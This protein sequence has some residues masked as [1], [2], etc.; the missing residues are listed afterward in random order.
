MQ[1]PMGEGVAAGDGVGERVVGGAVGS[2]MES[3][4]DGK[5][6]RRS[7]YTLKVQT[8]VCLT[9]H[10]RSYKSAFGM[11]KLRESGM[12]CPAKGEDEHGVRRKM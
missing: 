2:A 1:I 12:P 4:L 7:H 9:S 5:C 11:G 6:S 8:W 10:Q 3:W